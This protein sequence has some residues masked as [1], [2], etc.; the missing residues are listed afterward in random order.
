MAAVENQHWDQHYTMLSLDGSLPMPPGLAAAS[1][2]EPR[3]WFVSLARPVAGFQSAKG[4][5]KDAL[6]SV[7][8]SLLL[9][10]PPGIT[11]S[12]VCNG[13]IAEVMS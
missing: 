5:L 2:N 12:D 7:G 3:L 9:G 11:P 10:M 4:D 13:G 1:S 6:E 8:S